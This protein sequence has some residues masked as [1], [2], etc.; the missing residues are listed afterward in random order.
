MGAWN[1]ITNENV[2]NVCKWKKE[3]GRMKDE[4]IGDW[5]REWEWSI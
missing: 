1:G 2:N 4:W 3:N 5:K